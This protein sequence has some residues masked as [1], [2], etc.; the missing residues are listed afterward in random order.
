MASGWDGLTVRQIADIWQDE[1]FA[2][3]WTSVGDGEAQRRGTYL[4][5]LNAVDWSDHG[6]VARAIRAFESTIRAV[7]V[8][9]YSDDD[10]WLW[11]VRPLLE[12]D[13]YDLDDQGRITTRIPVALTPG[14]LS[15]LSDAT[16]IHAALQ[17]IAGSVD[18]DPALAIGTSKELIESTAKV[19]LSECGEPWSDKDDIAALVRRAQAK[20]KL[21]PSNSTVGPDGL[22]ALRKVLGGLTGIAIGVTELRNRGYGS[23]HGGVSAPAGLRPRHARLCVSAATAWCQTMLETLADPEAPWRKATMEKAN[24]AGT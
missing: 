15:N 12:R 10:R 11:S 23:G 18:T 2:P 14:A 21:Q 17:R 19:V 7:K 13:G 16:A 24:D 6:Q 4:A 9:P 3:D 22:D 8:P 20:L 1:G 5:Y